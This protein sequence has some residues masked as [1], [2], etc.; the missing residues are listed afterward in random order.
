MY[1]YLFIL[2]VITSCAGGMNLDNYEYIDPLN[3][4]IELIGRFFNEVS[5]EVMFNWSSSRIAFDFTGKEAIIDL[6]SHEESVFF[7]LYIDG[8][9]DKVIE[10]KKGR[11]KVK[12]F[13]DL[14]EGR[15]SISLERRNELFAGIS[16]FLGLYIDSNASVLPYS[17]LKD[18]YIEFIGDSLTAGYGVYA[19]SEFEPFLHSTEDSSV[20]HGAIAAKL[21]DS[22]YSI[23]AFSGKG[24]YRDYG[25]STVEPIPYFY[26]LIS[27]RPKQ[28]WDFSGRKPNLIVINLGT[29]DFAH[30]P[31]PKDKFIG[32]YTNFIKDINNYNKEAKILLVGGSYGQYIDKRTE[33]LNEIK[34]SLIDEN[35]NL[36]IFLM[37][38]ENPNLPKGADYHPGLEQQKVSGEYLAEGIKEFM[39]WK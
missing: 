23:V 6:Y 2:F 32:S 11:H 5:G 27:A 3:E 13:D 18:R 35:I 1:R 16:K 25:K 34:L 17:D 8:K 21:V 20:A 31:P 39:D 9:Q 15:H 12:L 10:V 24:I 28:E 22:D 14:D 7:N 30:D 26:P 19:N 4:N 38:P 33:Y 29:N 37:P 36:S